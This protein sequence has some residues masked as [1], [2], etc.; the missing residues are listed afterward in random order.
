MRQ[1]T[2]PLQVYVSRPLLEAIHDF[3]FQK[4]IPNRSTAVREL[5]RIGAQ[6]EW[7]EE[8]KQPPIEQRSN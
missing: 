8:V 2:R 6:A 3:Q 7:P 5:L 4:R 1:R